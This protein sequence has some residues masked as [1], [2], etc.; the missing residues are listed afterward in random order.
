MK[1]DARSLTALRRRGLVEYCGEMGRRGIHNE[2]IPIQAFS[3]KTARPTSEGVFMLSVSEELDREVDLHLRL[4]R[5]RA[6]ERA[7]SY[8]ATA[9]MLRRRA[10]KW[11]D[12]LDD[13]A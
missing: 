7:S 12:A 11:S 5:D 1:V 13:R 9:R 3:G 10:S 8:E 4:E 2:L 6:T